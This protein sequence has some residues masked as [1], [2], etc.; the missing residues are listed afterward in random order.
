MKFAGRCLYGEQ[1]LP[2][3]WERLLHWCKLSSK[4]QIPRTVRWWVF[5]I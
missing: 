2:S 5:N 3:V 4:R 1:H